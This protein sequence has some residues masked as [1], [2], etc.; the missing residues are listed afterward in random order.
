MKWAVSEEKL[1]KLSKFVSSDDYKPIGKRDI[2]FKSV[3]PFLD[4][5]GYDIESESVELDV[6]YPKC[7]SVMHV[8]ASLNGE[9]TVVVRVVDFDRDMQDEKSRVLRVL[10]ATEA[11][12][13]ILTDGIKYTVC[14]VTNKSDGLAYHNIWNLNLGRLGLR[15]LELCNFCCRENVINKESFEVVRKENIEITCS[16]FLDSLDSEEDLAPDWFFR[17]IAREAGC[18]DEYVSVVKEMFSNM[19]MENKENKR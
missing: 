19:L 17:A 5:L 3:L 1:N 10:K 16:E 11:C 6:H 13:G 7:G 8:Q 4:A 14:F 2:V 15:A 9:P 18:S 12:I